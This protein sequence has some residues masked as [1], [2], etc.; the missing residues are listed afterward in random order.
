MNPYKLRI[1][2]SMPVIAA[3]ARIGPPGPNHGALT[4]KPSNH[5]VHV[6]LLVTPPTQNHV[7]SAQGLYFLHSVQ[8]DVTKKC[9]VGFKGF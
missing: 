5:H 6:T 3:G 7:C 9:T 2:F 1:V 8:Y 4:A